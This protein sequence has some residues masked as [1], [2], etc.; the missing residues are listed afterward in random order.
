METTTVYWDYSGIMEWK[1]EWKAV[2]G[3]WGGVGWSFRSGLRLVDQYPMNF[4]IPD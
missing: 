3:G 4:L 2:P 1:I